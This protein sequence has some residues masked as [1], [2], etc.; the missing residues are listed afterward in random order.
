MLK[1]LIM[2]AIVVGQAVSAWLTRDIKAHIKNDYKS[3]VMRVGLLHKASE[4][5]IMIMAYGFGFGI[6]QLS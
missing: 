6:K 3:S 4:F 2:I 5:L 1:Y